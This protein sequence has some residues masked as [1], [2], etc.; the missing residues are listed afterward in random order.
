MHLYSVLPC[1]EIHRTEVQPFRL[2]FIRKLCAWTRIQK[3]HKRIYLRLRQTWMLLTTICTSTMV[4]RQLTKAN[5][6]L[7]QWLA[8]RY[9][10]LGNF[11]MWEKT[12][13]Y[14]R[15]KGGNYLNELFN[16][17]LKR[18]LYFQINETL[19]FRTKNFQKSGKDNS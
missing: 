10:W 7:S 5:E 17:C 9:I 8:T 1:G 11:M 2:F 13:Y 14:A 18:L 15:Q 12:L 6:T 16:T 19:F 3:F 4:H